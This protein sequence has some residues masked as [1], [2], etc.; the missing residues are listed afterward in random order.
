MNAPVGFEHYLNFINC[1]LQP[2]TGQVALPE[3]EVG[4]CAI[5][6]SRQSGCG[7]HVVAEKLAGYLQARAPQAAP[8]WTAFDRNL[9]QKVLADHHLPERLARF[10]PEDRIPEINE[11]MDELFG[12]HP[13][14]SELLQQISETILRLAEAGNVILL[15]R[16]AT[17]VTAR[18]PHMLHVRMIGSLERRIE[19]MQRFEG[20]S[21]QEATERIQREDLGRERYLKKHFGQDI[22]NPLLYHLVINTDFVSLD[23]ATRLIGDLA[24]SR[25]VPAAL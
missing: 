9:V 24:L 10:M 12:V 5:T 1:Q 23:E 16:G 3:R 15:G 2:P 13:P 8:P 18:L 7:A 6:I 11:I 19:N 20:L 17:I 4:K 25:S 22:N 14:T 21:R